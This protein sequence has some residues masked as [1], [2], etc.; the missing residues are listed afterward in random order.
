MRE[1][2]AE[3]DAALVACATTYNLGKRGVFAETMSMAKAMEAMAH[4][5]DEMCACKDTACA[6]KVSDDMAKWSQDMSK[7][8]DEPPRMTEEQTKRATEIGESM[9]KCMQTAMSAPSP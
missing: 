1:L 4:F 7:H 5:R 6:T 3:P 9:G 2:D 8:M